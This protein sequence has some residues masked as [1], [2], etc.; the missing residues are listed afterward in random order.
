MLAKRP[1]DPKRDRGS[2]INPDDKSPIR[3]MI[4][5]GESLY[6]ATDNCTGGDRLLVCLLA[7]VSCTVL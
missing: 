6:M 1:P 4:S 3:E 7:N 2:L 5:F